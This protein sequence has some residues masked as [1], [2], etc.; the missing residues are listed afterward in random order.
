[1]RRKAIKAKTFS[2][3]TCVEHSIQFPNQTEQESLDRVRPLTTSSLAK[4]S[5]SSRRHPILHVHYTYGPEVTGLKF[6][7]L[8]R[9]SNWGW[10][11]VRFRDERCSFCDLAMDGTMAV[12][13][14]HKSNRPGTTAAGCRVRLGR[15]GLRDEEIS[16]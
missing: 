1:M 14:P 3:S 10:V 15:Y 13:P 2:P 8:E 16:I 12:T 5:G 11:D 4:G 7:I 9:T 6:S